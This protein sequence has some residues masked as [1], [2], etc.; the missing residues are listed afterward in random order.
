MRDE[1]QT[2]KA[3]MKVT[4]CDE[5]RERERNN[6]IGKRKIICLCVLFNKNST[7]QATLLKALTASFLA[8]VPKI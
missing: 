1:R 5:S 7:P 6:S 2:N 4:G 3:S 8:L